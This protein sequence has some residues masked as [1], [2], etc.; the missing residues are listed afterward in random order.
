MNVN[1]LII[2]I[3]RFYINFIKIFDLQ[4]CKT[5]KVGQVT[6]MNFS[7]RISGDKTT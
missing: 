2:K 4:E 6:N 3:M 1:E 5:K 7:F